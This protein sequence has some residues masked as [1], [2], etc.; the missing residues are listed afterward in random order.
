M[1]C[2]EFS[3]PPEPCTIFRARG[4]VLMRC[5]P[6]RRDRSSWY[7]NQLVNIQHPR[8]E[9]ESQ[10]TAGRVGKEQSVQEIGT[11]KK[12]ATPLSHVH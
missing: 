3:V 8:S 2:T 11:G 7:P 5:A 12:Q 10:G 6:G 9:A 1:S 4:L